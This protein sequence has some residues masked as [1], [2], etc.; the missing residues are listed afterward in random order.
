MKIKIITKLK[1]HLKSITTS[2][3]KKSAEYPFDV[4]SKNSRLIKFQKEEYESVDISKMY[5]KEIVEIIA[6]TITRILF[7]L[8]CEYKSNV[9]INNVRNKIVGE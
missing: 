6:K 9:T 4:I 5:K 2:C 7:R 8:K 3:L 1:L